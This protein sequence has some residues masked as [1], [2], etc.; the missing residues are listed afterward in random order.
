M[1]DVVLTEY[2]FE[3]VRMGDRE[4]W[5]LQI[6]V[7]KLE[8]VDVGCYIS[9]EWDPMGILLNPAARWGILQQLWPPQANVVENRAVRVICVD[10]IEWTLD[11][12]REVWMG[13]NPLNPGP[14]RR[15]GVTR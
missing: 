1:S 9:I 4:T 13:M 7:G 11:V 14:F 15:G 8:R 10:G 5:G 2:R 6:P 12:D 3:S